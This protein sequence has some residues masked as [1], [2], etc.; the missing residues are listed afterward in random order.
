MLLVIV[1]QTAAAASHNVRLVFLIFSFC[2]ILQKD[3]LFVLVG[4][5]PVL[6]VVLS[7]FVCCCFCC[8]VSVLYA[9]Y[10]SH[11]HRGLSLIHI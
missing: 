10:L 3:A 8:F 6:V 11:L 4:V 5:K 9:K 2:L 1:P 7:V